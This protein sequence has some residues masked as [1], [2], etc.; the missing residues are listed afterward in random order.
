MTGPSKRIATTPARNVR[1]PIPTRHPARD[2]RRL[3]P[4]PR[5]EGKTTPRAT[6]PTRPR[7]TTETAAI[8]ATCDTAGAST[9]G[10]G[11]GKGRVGEEGRT[12]GAPYHLKKKKKKLGDG[13]PLTKKEKRMKNTFL[14]WWTTCDRK[15]LRLHSVSARSRVLRCR[16]DERVKIWSD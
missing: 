13:G 9:G 6:G 8:T 14:G 11:S 5:R 1:L 4:R 12:R 16:Y 3:R 10:G 2:R 15:Q 7:P